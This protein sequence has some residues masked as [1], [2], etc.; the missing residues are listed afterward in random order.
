MSSKVTVRNIFAKN[1]LSRQKHTHR[2]DL[3]LLLSNFDLIIKY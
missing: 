2:T 1:V 3:C